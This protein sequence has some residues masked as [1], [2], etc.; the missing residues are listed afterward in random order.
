MGG[1]DKLTAV[2]ADETNPQPP[3]VPDRPILD[4]VP[5]K[6]EPRRWWSWLTADPIDPSKSFVVTR[7]IFLRGLGLV[8][9]I[10]FVSLWV[11]IDGL[12]GS[13]GVLPLGN[14]LAAVRAQSPNISA[15]H[16]FLD[17]PTLCWISS[18]NA[19]L[20]FIC[21]GGTALSCAA[22]IGVL[23]AP[24][25]ALLW[26][27]YLSLVH[28]GQDFL[29]F[30][31]DSLLLE[32]GFLAI[33]F[34][35]LELLLR[36]MP[37]HSRGRPIRYSHPSRIVLLLLWWLLFRLMFLSGMVKATART[38]Y[39]RAFTAMRYHYET[40]PLPTWTSW[41]VHLLP[42]WIQ[43]IS[44]G[45]VFFIEGLVPL[46]F[47]TPRRLRL[48][49][50]G[51][52][53]LLQLLIAGTGNYGFFN[54]LAIVLCLTLIDDA[55][56]AKLKLRIDPARSVIRG[57]RWPTAVLL[58][59][60]IAI[61]LLSLVPSLSR[62]RLGD[63][64]PEWLQSCYEATAPFELVNPYGLFED[65]TTRRPEIIIEGSNDGVRWREY[66][67][68]WKPGDLKRRPRFCTPHMPRLDWQMW[69]AALE[70]DQ[71]G[72]A[73]MW[74]YNLVLRLHEGSPAVL[75]LMGPNPFPDHPPRHIRLV[76]YD[77]QFTSAAERR[78]SGGWWTR[79]LIGRTRELDAPPDSAAR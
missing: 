8:Y 12:I 67:F 30:Q 17:L 66:S 27:F 36:P 79:T 57:V 59:L 3:S 54:L 63:S 42:N 68:K 34:A 41:Y 10:A 2:T 44:V 22:I 16:R 24:V 49:A 23:P 37:F 65:M 39:W 32:T 77:Y 60:G 78:K 29:G 43:A 26:L 4:Y 58:P 76:L 71:Y 14:Y 64:V 15:V 25:L 5:P 56:W 13:R 28:A 48:F 61:V 50:C 11:Q 6:E 35:P 46:L 74:L 55:T 21:M 75:D 40:Q 31:W 1:G 69:F 53:L 38:E 72:Q 18:S 7:A 62:A 51:M 33:F 73:P 45:G 47:F 70:M 19:F 20:H 9:L 52:T